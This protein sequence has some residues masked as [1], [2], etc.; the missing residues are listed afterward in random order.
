MIGSPCVKKTLIVTNEIRKIPYSQN[1]MNQV[2]IQLHY[3]FLK[4]ITNTNEVIN[5]SSQRTYGLYCFVHFCNTQPYK[6][7]IIL[8]KRI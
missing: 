8:K 3:L 1:K 5:V 6:P 4:P 2:V 7:L